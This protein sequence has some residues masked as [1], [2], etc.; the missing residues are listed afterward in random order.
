MILLGT[1]VYQRSRLHKRLAIS[2]SVGAALSAS[3]GASAAGGVDV[4][5]RGTDAC[6]ERLLP[7]LDA[8]VFP[9][10][11]PVAA[12]AP[13]KWRFS[14]KFTTGEGHP[15]ALREMELDVDKDVRLNVE[16]YPS[17]G[18]RKVRQSSDASVMAACRDALLGKG[19]AHLE[20]AQAEGSPSKLPGHLLIFNAGKKGGAAKILVR[21]SFP[22]EV[23]ISTISVTKH[24]EGIHSVARVPRIA[25][26]MG[27]LTDFTFTVGSTHRRGV[28]KV[29]YFE[30]RCPDGVFK[31]NVK[32]MLFRNEAE[33]PGEAASTS[34]KGSLAVPCTPSR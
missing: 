27:S 14:G 28:E 6:P 23:A 16:G 12:Y 32:R 5:L 18:I 19:E 21:A 1:N 20:I 8:A 17:C 29:G 34:V 13:V 25:D 4:C 3:V 33:T 31:A 9:R 22:R 15:P 7:T 26:G 10:K 30:A 2:L 24:A 11:L